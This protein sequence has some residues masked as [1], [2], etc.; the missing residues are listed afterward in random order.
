MSLPECKHNAKSLQEE[1]DRE[2]TSCI[3]KF[4]KP[5][6]G[7]RRVASLARNSSITSTW[8]GF[9]DLLSCYSHL[10]CML[11]TFHEYNVNYI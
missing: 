11:Q 7:I 6:D 1:S 10:H 4:F 3:G 5:L 9:F 2:L 8:W